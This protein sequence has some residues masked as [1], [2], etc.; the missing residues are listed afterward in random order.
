VEFIRAADDEEVSASVFDNNLLAS[1]TRREITRVTKPSY[2]PLYAS[3]SSVIPRPCQNVL[4]MSDEHEV[5]SALN[6]LS[7][8]RGV[9]TTGGSQCL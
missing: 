3:I 9:S 1:V 6:R 5:L 2:S 7:T 8:I 4:A